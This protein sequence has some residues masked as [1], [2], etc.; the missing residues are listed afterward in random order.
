MG[1]RVVELHAGV[2]AIGL[3][4][5][6]RRRLASLALVEVN[7]RAELPFRESLDRLRSSTGS[8]SGGAGGLQVLLRA[9]VLAS[10]AAAMSCF[11]GQQAPAASCCGASCHSV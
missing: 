5:A 10:P 11:M 3:S 9:M 1:S 4:L 6:S 2:G 7:P 8:T